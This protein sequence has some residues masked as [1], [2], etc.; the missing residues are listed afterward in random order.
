MDYLFR[1][2][3]CVVGAVLLGLLC[4]YEVLTHG[5]G[6]D[7]MRIGPW[8]SAPKSGTLDVEPYT[9]AMIARS[10][11]I[12]LG[13]TEGVSFTASRDSE[14]RALDGHCSYRLA[15]SEPMARAWTLTILHRNGLPIEGDGFYSLTSPDIVRLQA[16]Q[17]EV[18]LA[19]SAR[20]M[21]WLTLP[22]EGSF[23]I[24]LRLYDTAVSLSSGALRIADLPRIEKEACL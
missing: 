21:N 1:L 8:Q 20:P 24:M 22:T 18:R 17:I 4:S 19:T 6:F 3:A 13:I 7:V 15:G 11:Q 2:Y 14:G 5:L 16:G 12:P 23:L 10:G 9:K